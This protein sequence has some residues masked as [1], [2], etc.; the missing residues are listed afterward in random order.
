MCEGQRFLGTLMESRGSDP[1]GYV[2]DLD[3]SRP[4]YHRKAEEKLKQTYE[5]IRK[6]LEN[7][8]K[9]KENHWQT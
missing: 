7:D 1:W 6:A 8:G 4:G 3:G 5:N 2:G 9:A